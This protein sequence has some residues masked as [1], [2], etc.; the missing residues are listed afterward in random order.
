MNMLIAAAPAAAPAVTPPA[1]A[2]AAKTKL[3]RDRKT[4]EAFRAVD[5]A[6]HDRDHKRRVT[7]AVATAEDNAGHWRQDVER[8]EPQA[9]TALAAF[10]AAEDRARKARENA[11]QKFAAYEAGK[12]KVPV[13]EETDALFLADKA[14]Q[15][16]GDA[17]QVMERLQG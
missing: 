17:E 8:L 2:A 7:E 5:Q 12:G 4:F 11:R 15:V 10:R 16:A 1:Y 13:E 6:E 14:D 3:D 9:E